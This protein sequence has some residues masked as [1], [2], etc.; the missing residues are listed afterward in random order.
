MTT[1]LSVFGTRPEAIKMAPRSKVSC[2]RVWGDNQAGFK[3]IV[4]LIELDHMKPLDLWTSVIQLIN[5]C[6]WLLRRWM[7]CNSPDFKLRN[8]C[9]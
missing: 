5:Q 3:I 6:L 1:I 8:I 7:H 2:G 9:K 4:V